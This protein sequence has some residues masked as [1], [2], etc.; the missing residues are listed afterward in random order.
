MHQRARYHVSHRTRSSGVI[1]WHLSI[2]EWIAHRSTEPKVASS[3]DDDD[4]KRKKSKGS[5]SSGGDG[6]GGG[7][8]RLSEIMQNNDDDDYDYVDT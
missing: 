5:S 4:E 2:Y 6:D 1:G 8:F 3:D 7:T